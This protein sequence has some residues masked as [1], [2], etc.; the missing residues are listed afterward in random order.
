MMA[1]MSRL[2]EKLGPSMS[3]DTVA[4]VAAAGFRLVEVNNIFLDVVKTIRA[5][6]EDSALAC[7]T[8]G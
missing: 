5:Q 4:N 6:K 8:K 7:P 3:R 2:S 1:L